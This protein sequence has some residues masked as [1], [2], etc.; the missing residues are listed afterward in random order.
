MIDDAATIRDGLKLLITKYECGQNHD[1]GAF[2]P[3][4]E[5]CRILKDL[6]TLVENGAPAE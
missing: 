2:D 1:E 5:T 6:R 4:C 3:D